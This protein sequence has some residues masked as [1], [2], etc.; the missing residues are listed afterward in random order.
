MDVAASEPAK[1]SYAHAVQKR[2]SPR[3]LIDHI[4]DRGGTH[5][6]P[7][8]VV[9]QTGIIF[10][11]CGNEFHCVARK[12]EIL[13]INVPQ[14]DLLMAAV[15]R[16]QPAVCVFLEKNTNSGLNTFDRRH[17]QVA[18]G[19]VYLQDFFFPGYTVEFIAA[20]NKD[21]PSLHYDDN[22]FLVR[23]APV[24]NVI[25]Q[26]PGTGPLLHGVR[27]GYFG[28]LASGHI[29]RIN[30][31]HAFYQALGE[32]TFNP[33]AGRPVT[34]NAQMAAVEISYDKDWMRY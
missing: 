25:D 5:Q 6:E 16:I 20:W 33:I 31:T 19:N 30:L 18:L 9:M 12:E 7:V 26:N 11:P 32:D 17:Q 14:C 24:G 10:V 4:S 34:I 23:P 21:D 22:G 27:V 8:V 1:I 29:H 3:V 13:Q 2:A 15:E 28:W